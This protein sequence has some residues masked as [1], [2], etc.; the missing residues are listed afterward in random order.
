MALT[1]I[2]LKTDSFHAS[3][4][5]KGYRPLFYHEISLGLLIKFLVRVVGCWFCV[6]NRNLSFVHSKMNKLFFFSILTLADPPYFV[7]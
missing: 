7:H 6:L 3:L 5:Q 2:H 4:I 1:K